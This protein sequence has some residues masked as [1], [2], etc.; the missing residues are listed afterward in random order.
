MQRFRRNICVSQ[1]ELAEYV[2]LT[3]SVISRMETGRG[4][5][6]YMTLMKMARTFDRKIDFV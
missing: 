5:P 6:S 2:G 3:Q 1:E 4:N